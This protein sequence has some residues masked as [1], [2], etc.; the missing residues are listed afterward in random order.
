[1]KTKLRYLIVGLAAVAFAQDKTALPL[2]ASGNVSLPL[3][4][5]NRLVDLAGKPVK[6]PD[7]PPVPFTIQSADLKFQVSGGAVTGTIQLD[8]EVF[9]K[10]A[11]LVPLL[12]GLTILDAR[13]KGTELPILQSGG[14]HSAVLPGSQSFSVTLAWRSPSSLAS[15][16]S[17]FRCPPRARRGSRLL[18]PAIAPSS[19]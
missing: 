14:T 1:M 8:G 13:E 6:K 19:T 16:P 3:D 7:T 4:E 12:S 2:P 10:S 9:R 11:T 15:L 18:S 5:Y 17:S